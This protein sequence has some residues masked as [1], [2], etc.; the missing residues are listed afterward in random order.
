MNLIIG[1]NMAICE[2]IYQKNNKRY[3]LKLKTYINTKTNHSNSI[4]IVNES[5]NG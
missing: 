2:S 4:I 1:I 3:N 5:Q